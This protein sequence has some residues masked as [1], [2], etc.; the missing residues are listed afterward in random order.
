MLTPAFLA[1]IF[2]AALIVVVV[3]FGLLRVLAIILLAEV[4]LET[5]IGLLRGISV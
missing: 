1:G 2:T 4:P 3:V 5:G